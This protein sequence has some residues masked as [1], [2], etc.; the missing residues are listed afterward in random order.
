MCDI[1]PSELWVKIVNYTEEISLLL[2]NTKFFELFNLVNI[3]T[4]VIKYIVENNLVS[5]LK[6]ITLLKKLNHPIIE[7][8]IVSSEL[9]NKYLI[10]S[11]KIF[12][13]SRC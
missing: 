12:G 1:L 7:K 6:Y 10:E 4:D 5:I 9:L 13:I 11:C 8:N 3:K 2:T